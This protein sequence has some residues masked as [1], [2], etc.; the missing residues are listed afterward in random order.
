MPI[1]FYKRLALNKWLF[2]LF[3]AESFEDLAKHLTDD[4]LEGFDED[5]ISRFVQIL[6]PHLPLGSSL[7]KGRLL[8]YDENIV[9][10]WKAMAEPRSHGGKLITPKY[11]QYLSLLFTEI[12]LERYFQ[13]KE[14]LLDE[15][16]AFLVKFNDG[17]RNADQLGKFKLTEL[18]K[19][20]FWN[21]TGS[22]KTLLMHINILQYKHYLKRYGHE[23]DLNRIILLTPNEGLSIQHLEEFKLSKMPAHMF[24]KDQT[25]RHLKQI[26]IIDIHKLK[27]DS[28]DKTVA[29][30]SF[31]GNNL[32]LVDEGHKGSGGK[33]WMEKRNKLCEEG[34][35]F[36]Y[37][38]TFGQALKAANKPKL[39]EQYAKCIIFDYS[40]RYFYKDG[41]GKDYKILNLSEETDQERRDLY[42]SACL[43]S[44]YQQV[45]LFEEGYKDLRPFN[46]HRPLWVF[47]G[48]KVNAVRTEQGQKV[49]DVTAV[50]RF[51]SA[52]TW[53]KQ[54]SITA[55]D[56]ILSGTDGLTDVNGRSIFAATFGHL[57]IAK[58][59][60][61]EVFNDILKRVF[62]SRTPGKI[63][64]EHLKGGDGEI[65]LKLG[66][67][68]DPFGVINVGDAKQLWTLCDELE[69]LVTIEK[70]FSESLFR[71]INDED[72]GINLLIGSKKFTEGWNSWR[73][74]TMGLMNIGRREGSEI[75]QLFGRGVRLK[76][77]EFC[78]KRSKEVR[79]VPKPDFITTCETLN[80]FGVRA[81]YM[82]QFKEFL[83]EEGLPAEV[84]EFVLPAIRNLGKVKLKVPSVSND[85]NFKKEKKTTLATPPEMLTKRP[86]TLDWYPKI[87]AIVSE[88]HKGA[89]ADGE[90]YE[91][92]RL[93]E[94]HLAF[95]NWDEI[96]FELVRFKNERSW[97]NFNLNKPLMKEL[98]L[99]GGWFKLQ[100]PEEEIEPTSFTNIRRCQEVVVALLKKYCDR[101]YGYKKDEFEKPHMAYKEI[102]PDDPNFFDEYRIAVD[103]S[104]ENII[105]EVQELQEAIDNGDLKDRGLQLQS[106]VFQQHLYYPLLHVNGKSTSDLVKVTPVDL[107]EGEK[108]FVFDLRK[109]YDTNTSWFEGRELYLLRN[110]SKGKG[111]GFFE[112]ENFHP[113]FIL[114]LVQ[115]GKQHIAFVDPKGILRLRG[116]EDP[117]IMFFEKV[118]ELE[119]RLK[120]NDVTMTSF[121]VSNTP[122]EE[123]KWWTGGDA[124]EFSKRN[125]LFQKEDK[126]VYIKTMLERLV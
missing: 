91:V 38:A 49:S 61:E 113:D 12:Y 51:L 41:Y 20:A 26:E 85:V 46:I 115:D 22:G 57:K 111:I 93:E 70:D 24:R 16:N 110:L 95:V 18:N 34:F 107:N 89:F 88:A 83:E 28:G 92:W 56:R 44:F 66:E 125:V 82:Q 15:L 33:E 109:F 98:V 5:N 119:Q 50:L 1:P 73:V 80:I 17:L 94:R 124:V 65:A 117:K 54:A 37:S 39:T 112:A 11:F 35:S 100:I 52:F 90:K 106:F 114:W 123:V 96:F 59:S 116:L 86:F 45:R 84:E 29:V 6:I 79:G 19:L 47:V 87:Q 63:H 120:D 21:A 58:L 71:K 104:A 40:Y 105:K 25:S 23:R 31:E 103:K 3:G 67:G 68:N 42:L 13:D 2:S 9:R 7:T 72:G 74:S 81:D 76:G 30:D 36:E 101:F 55:L 126:N 64:V 75:I 99:E 108:D 122:L 4:S 8:G 62:H 69:E 32:V 97:Y 48:G 27:D 10:H 14:A 77:Y 43:L 121:I 118:K 60:A 53:N 102:T 78:L